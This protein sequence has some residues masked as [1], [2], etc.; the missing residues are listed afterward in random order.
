MAVHSCPR[1]STQPA[2][3]QTPVATACHGGSLC[4]P[5]SVVRAGGKLRHQLRHWRARA[6]RQTQKGTPCSI[7][8]TRGPQSSRVHRVDTEWPGRG[9]S[10]SK[11]LGR[12]RSSAA[13]LPPGRV[14]GSTPRNATLQTHAQGPGD[15]H[16][17][18]PWGQAQRRGSGTGGR[19][20]PGPTR[21]PHRVTEETLRCPRR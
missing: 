20:A 3:Q 5:E 19:A 7:P 8:L 13:N 10:H 14:N 17:P 2:E 9:G 21:C 16:V 11:L 6:L 1:L 18:G 15:G 12:A 4:L